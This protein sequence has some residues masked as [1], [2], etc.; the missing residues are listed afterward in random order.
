MTQSFISWPKITPDVSFNVRLEWLVHDGCCMKTLRCLSVLTLSASFW[1]SLPAPLSALDEKPVSPSSLEIPQFP[2]VMDF[3]KISGVVVQGGAL[4]HW[5]NGVKTSISSP[6]R[7]GADYEIKPDGEVL[8][9]TSALWR[10]TEGQM[11]FHDGSI[12]LDDGTMSYLEDH[13]IQQAGKLVKVSGGKQTVQAPGLRLPNG[14]IVREYGRMLMPNGY[15]S[16]LQD[17]QVLRADGEEL[18]AWDTIQFQNG[19]VTLFKDGSKLALA[20]GRLMVMNDGTKVWGNGMISRRT[21][22]SNWDEVKFQ[23]P[24]GAMVRVPRVA[25][26]TNKRRAERGY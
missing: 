7:F 26:A 12:L 20:P 15:L 6:L 24:E 13:Y 2:A 14:I 18:A 5:D 19:T 1:L 23:L 10:L 17:G 21:R 4:F 9:A 8:R 3:P 16:I 22:L 11:L 25:G